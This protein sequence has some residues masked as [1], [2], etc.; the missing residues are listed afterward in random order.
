[1]DS[2]PNFHNVLWE[3][4][5]L[6]SNAYIESF[7]QTFETVNAAIEIV[8]VETFLKHLWNLCIMNYL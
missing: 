3:Q 5:C 4:T 8:G 1:M 2:T 7:N 6:M